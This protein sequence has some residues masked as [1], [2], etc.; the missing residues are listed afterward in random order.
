MPL[1]LGGGT[2]LNIQMKLRIDCNRRGVCLHDSQLKMIEITWIMTN[3][4]SQ[5]DNMRFMEKYQGM[6]ACGKK[7]S[8]IQRIERSW[9]ICVSRGLRTVIVH[10]PGLKWHECHRES[11]ICRGFLARSEAERCDQT[12]VLSRIM[13]PTGCVALGKLLN[14][15]SWWF[16]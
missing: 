11:R 7:S 3:G 9:P 10:G 4:G 13:T 8:D 5:K 2:A 16:L 15:S 1:Y 14:P 12:R 6:H